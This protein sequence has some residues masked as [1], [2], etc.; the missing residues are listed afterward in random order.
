MKIARIETITVSAG[1]KNWLV[2]R[3][4]TDDGHTGL[5]EGTLNGFVRTIETA[6]H[7]L[8]HLAL[9]EDATRPT[10]LAKRLAES[11]SN[12][13][14]HVHKHAIASIESACWD[15]LG[16]SVG[17]PMHALVGGRVRDSVAGYANGWYRTERTPDAFEAAAEHVVAR[18]FKAL[19][20]DPFGTA[21]GFL[22]EAELDLALEIVGRL[23][24]RFPQVAVLIDVHA[25]FTQAEAIRVARAFEPLGVYWWEEPSS[26]ELESSASTVARATTLRV[27]T[28]ETF[29]MPGQFFTLAR[30]GGVSIWQPEPMSLGGFG[31]TLVVAN[32]AATAGAWIAPH[33]SGGPVATAL[34]LQLAACVPNFLIQEHFDPFNEPWTADL[35]TWRPTIDADTGHLSLP[36]APGLGL[37]LVDEVAAA[38]PYDPNA[39]LNVYADGWERR[40]GRE[41]EVHGS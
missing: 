28:G 3:V 2:T 26:R 31:S 20:L 27:A 36:T 33:Q 14:G 37:E 13:G 32:L 1:W 16:K 22:E 6:V 39:Y 17:L 29:H 38:H 35:V 24:E 7:E 30:E 9:G 18:G 8:E 5:G 21:Q 12:D 4:H 19:K 15:I 25:R 23:R 40:L 34:C 41:G 10:A 11:V